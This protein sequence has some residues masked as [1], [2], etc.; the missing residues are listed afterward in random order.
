MIKI[1]QNLLIHP[2]ELQPIELGLLDRVKNENT[3]ESI[4][5]KILNGEIEAF[6]YSKNN[7]PN[8]LIKLNIP[9]IEA[10]YQ[11]KNLQRN[12]VLFEVWT[13]K[14]SV[15]ESFIRL[16]TVEGCTWDEL[17]IRK[18]DIT[19][20]NNPN[21]K[22]ID[23][24]ISQNFFNDWVKKDKWKA[25]EA[26]CLLSEIDP[27]LHI[28]NN[29][30]INNI[31]ALKLLETIKTWGLLTSTEQLPIFEFINKCLL[32]EIPI[33]QNLFS[34]IERKFIKY[35]EQTSELEKHIKS[36]NH[37]KLYESVYNATFNYNEN[38]LSLIKDHKEK[39]NI[40]NH[41]II[42]CNKP[43]ENTYKLP[44]CVKNNH[45]ALAYLTKPELKLVIEANGY[46]VYM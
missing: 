34:R 8:W 41:L 42:D 27:N 15:P 24:L 23:E 4:T 38:E 25:T 16:E 31:E 29:Q 9:T 43:E 36:Q 39:Q 35:L 37:M 20:K 18:V 45:G 40:I 3:K 17:K 7:R 2:D 28:E 6:V 21:E 46:P 30:I 32:E 22:K 44:I 10:L 12:I 14:N 26:A 11:I 33:N 1:E 5:D 19:T 13:R